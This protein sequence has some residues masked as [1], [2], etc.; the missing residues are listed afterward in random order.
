M[1]DATASRARGGYITLISAGRHPLL[2]VSCRSV[3][4]RSRHCRSPIPVAVGG[5]GA[6]VRIGVAPGSSGRDVTLIPA[7]GPSLL[8]GACSG[9]AFRACKR[10][11]P[12]PR[13]G[14]IQSHECAGND[15]SHCRSQ[16]SSCF[17]S[18]LLS[19]DRQ[20]QLRHGRLLRYGGG[21]YHRLTVY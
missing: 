2:N 21:P 18:I 13:L 12:S 17:H 16:N 20:H 9:S 1:R 4:G 14:L 5:R 8:D 19:R 3:A 6:P 15:N 7:G 10:R 11:A